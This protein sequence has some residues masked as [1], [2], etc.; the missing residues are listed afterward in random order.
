[1]SSVQD[2]P[3]TPRYLRHR[4]ERFQQ[5]DLRAAADEIFGS[6]RRRRRPRL[7]LASAARLALIPHGGAFLFA[8]DIRLNLDPLQT[9]QPTSMSGTTAEAAPRW[10]S[11]AVGRRSRRPV[12]A[13]RPERGLAGPAARAAAGRRASRVVRDA[14]P[15]RRAALPQL[16]L[17]VQIAVS[18]VWCAQG[19]G[20]FM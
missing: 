1:M 5:L 16:L 19:D 18:R 8:G 17:L 11:L 6:I 10:R 12:A 13:L 7:D 4:R 20:T 15:R 9:C 2:G 14:P 3:R